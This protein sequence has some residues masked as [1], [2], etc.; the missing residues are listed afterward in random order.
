MRGVDMV[1]TGVVKCR[2]E[3][4]DDYIDY[5]TASILTYARF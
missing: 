5:C 1:P 3:C 2:L 4:L